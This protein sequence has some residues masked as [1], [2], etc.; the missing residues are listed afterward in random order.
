MDIVERIE[1]LFVRHGDAPYEGARREAISALEH[2]LQ[3]AQLAEW[4]NA[5]ESL[6]AAAF[7]HDVGHFL[8]AEAIAR[9]DRVDDRHEDLA[10]PFL[11]AGFDASV[12][13][14]VRLHVQA[15]RFLVRVDEHYARQLSPASQ[16]SLALQGG[17]MDD[18]Q[19]AAF[20][21]LPFARDAVQ[22]RRWDDLA[23]EPGRRT[24]SLDWYLALLRDVRERP[25]LD[26]KTG[27]G[28]TSVA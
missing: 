1:Q 8:A 2:A 10:L 15:K 20:E 22:L 12:T 14:P 7:L 13:E 4:A 24:P 25:F 19:L 9:D 28:A 17:P 18:D 11:S 27:I 23:K 5:D 16:H 6:V 26:S 21:A 3:C